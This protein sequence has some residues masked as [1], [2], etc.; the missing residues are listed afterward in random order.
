MAVTYSGP[1]G[2]VD[3]TL[4]GGHACKTDINLEL[5]FLISDS[6]KLNFFKIG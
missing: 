3:L 4:N 2:C 1:P 6:G 5:S